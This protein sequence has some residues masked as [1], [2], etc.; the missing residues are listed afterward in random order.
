MQTTY[1]LQMD[2]ARSSITNNVYRNFSKNN[3]KNEYILI[4]NCIGVTLIIAHAYKFG[5]T[6]QSDVSIFKNKY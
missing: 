6:L 4:R 5:N 1:Y 2:I 3:K